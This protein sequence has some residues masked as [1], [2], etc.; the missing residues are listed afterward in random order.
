[1]G[2]MLPIE[3]ELRLGLVSGNVWFRDVDMVGTQ[4]RVAVTVNAIQQISLNR[5]P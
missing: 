3:D 5:K 1:M 4:I 2:R